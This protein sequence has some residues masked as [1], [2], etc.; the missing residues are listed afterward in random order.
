MTVLPA[1]STLILLATAVVLLSFESR[2]GAQSITDDVAPPPLKV[3]SKEE[4]T[5][6]GAVT[7]VKKHTQLALDLMSSRL[8]Q[9]ETFQAQENLDEMYKQLG[10]F[11]GLM[12]HT[13]DFLDKSDR[14]SRKV[15]YNYKR[16]EMGLRQFRPRLELMRRDVPI[17]YEPYVRHLIG[18]LREARTKAI[19]PLYSDSVVPRIKP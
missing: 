7:D 6:L 17:R 1:R 4:R 19:E 15:L 12:D 16:F 18:Y 5:Q 14:D 11:H 2:A 10:G 3:V 8:K 9:A 13:L